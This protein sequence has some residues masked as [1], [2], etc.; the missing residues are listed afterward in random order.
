MIFEDKSQLS[1]HIARFAMVKDRNM[2]N[3]TWT[4]LFSRND[5][6]L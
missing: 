1:L 3:L 5:E 6:S 4:N 2:T